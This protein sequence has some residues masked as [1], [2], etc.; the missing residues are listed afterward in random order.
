MAQRPSTPPP[1]HELLGILG[2]AL[3]RIGGRASGAS[4]K[5]P[6]APIAPIAY[7]PPV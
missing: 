1:S 6:V 5:A 2:N 3:W 4:H 7:V